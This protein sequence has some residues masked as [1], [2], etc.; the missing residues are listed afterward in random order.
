MGALLFTVKCSSGKVLCPGMRVPAAFR[1]ILN[2]LND[3]VMRG[4]S[5][6]CVETWVHLKVA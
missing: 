6:L 5:H 4:F 3:M 2:E 1:R